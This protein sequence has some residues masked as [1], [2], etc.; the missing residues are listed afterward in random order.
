MKKIRMLLAEDHILVREGFRELIESQEDME[1][2]GEAAN[3]EEAIQLVAQFMPDVVLMDI[4][5]PKINGVEATKTIKE[6][7]PSV[8]VLILTAYDSDEFIFAIAE[9]GAAGYL[10]KTVQRQE[11]FSSIRAVFHGESVLHPTIVE[12]LLK[13]LMYTEQKKDKPVGNETLSHRELE[14]LKLGAR[15]LPNK[16]IAGELSMRVR[17]VQ[18]HWRNIFNKLGVSSRTEAVMRGLQNDWIALE[19]AVSGREDNH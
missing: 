13:R 4:A 15:G 10:L 8:A 9:A 2:V 7:Y 18:T 12:K 3:G 11:L 5:M 17:T 19:K 16:Q 6:C 14:V 1:I